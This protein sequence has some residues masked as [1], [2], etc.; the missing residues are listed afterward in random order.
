MV[1]RSRHGGAHT[2]RH[3]SRLHHHDVH[4]GSTDTGGLGIAFELDVSL[5]NPTPEQGRLAVDRAY[6]V[7]PYSNATR[8]NFDVALSGV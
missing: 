2:C 7:C 8:D 6:E 1:D 4:L 3:D 5:P